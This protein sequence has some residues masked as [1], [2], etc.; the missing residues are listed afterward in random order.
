LTARKPALFS[1]RL[2]DD[3]GIEQGRIVDRQARDLQGR[4]GTI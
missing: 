1:Q 3:E 4:A 2:R